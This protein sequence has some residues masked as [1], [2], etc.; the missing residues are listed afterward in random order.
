MQNIDNIDKWHPLE[1]GECLEFEKKGKRRVRLQVNSPAPVCFFLS[2]PGEK[3]VFLAKTDGLDTI[4]FSVEG[5]FSVAPD[6]F[7]Q[8]YTAER[9]K[10]HATGIGEKFTKI[11]ERKPRNREFELMQFNMMKNVNRRLEQQRAEYEALLAVERAKKAEIDDGP[12]NTAKS[13]KSGGKSDDNA[14]G[15]ASPD[16]GGAA[17]AGEGGAGSGGG[18]DESAEPA[19]A[20]KAG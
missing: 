2:R 20:K 1:K 14:K 9:E 10:I 11:M 15:A 8:I 5:E 3:P 13:A 12:A 18:A 17:G 16:K 19:Q 4:V 7:C 6:A